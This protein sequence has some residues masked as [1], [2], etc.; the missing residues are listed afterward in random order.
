VKRPDR[1]V[2]IAGAAVLLVSMLMVLSGPAIAQQD[3]PDDPAMT[4]LFSNTAREFRAG[5]NAIY[6]PWVAHD[7]DFGLGG[8][9]TSISVQNLEDRDGQIY[10]YRGNGNGTWSQVTTA[11]LSAYASKTF[12]ASDLG[13]SAGDGAPMAVL[14]WHITPAAS[15]TALIETV[16]TLSKPAGVAGAS[17]QVLA[18]VVNEHLSESY[19]DPAPFMAA[20][21]FEYDEVVYEQ[22]SMVPWS[23]QEQLQA[24]LDTVNEDNTGAL[25]NPFGGLNADGDCL[26]RVGTSSTGG[27][28]F[29]SIVLGGIA[30]MAVAG[31]A[32]PF[33]SGADRAVSGY[34][35]INGLEVDQFNNWYLPIVQTNCGPG[36][37]WD[38]MIRVANLSDQNSA[39]T[40]RFFA[41]DD[42]S[43]SFDTGFQV[44][45]LLS[46][47]D[48]WHIDLGS[49]V[50]EG[51]V[52]SAHIL[53]D[54]WV[55]PMVDRYKVGYSMWLTNTG[56]AANFESIAQVENANGR[57]ALFAPH[58]LMG[59]FGWNTGINVANLHEG[60]N[61]IS[62]QY[63]NMVG[64]A[65]QVL[66]QR[67]AAH[68]MTYFYDPSQDGPS[69]GDPNRG[70][71]GSAI[72]W[73]DQ[74]VAV[75][76][77]ATKYP[78]A[79][80][81][82]GA[83][84]FQGT[85]YNATQNVYTFQAIP[86]VQKGNPAD[87]MGATSG[88][89]IMNPN[90]TAATANVY[91]VD[92]SGMNASNFGISGVTIPGFAN[93]FVYGLWQHNLPNGFFGAAQVISNVPVAAV[94]ANV[95]YQVEGDGSAIFNSFNPCGY[96]R[97]VAPPGDGNRGCYLGDPFDVSG[98]SVIKTFIDEDGAP[99]AGVQFHITGNNPA[100]PYQRHGVSGVD[101]T[102]HFA[103]VPVGEYELNVD[104]VPTGYMK[105]SNPADT[106]TLVQG[107]DWIE[108]NILYWGSGFHKTVCVAGTLDPEDLEAR[109]CTDI[110]LA[111]VD[112]R[113][114]E[115]VGTTAF[116]LPVINQIVFDQPTGSDGT[117]SGVLGAGNYMLCM[118]NADGVIT[119]TNGEQVETYLQQELTFDP[120]VG[121]LCGT[122]GPFELFSIEPGGFVELFNPVFLKAEGIL[123][124][125]VRTSSTPLAGVEICI[126]QEFRI[127]TIYD[128]AEPRCLTTGI[129]G[130]VTFADVHNDNVLFYDYDINPHWFE[131]DTSLMQTV[132]FTGRVWIEVNSPT[133]SIYCA[134]GGELTMYPNIE[135]LPCGDSPLNEQEQ[136]FYGRYVPT[137]DVAQD[138]YAQDVDQDGNLVGTFDLQIEMTSNP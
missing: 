85:T 42:G 132:V 98:G 104:V 79:S 53:S 69:S 74:P 82:S 90:A 115:V 59:Y 50:P 71:V 61:D 94:S 5:S 73:S 121:L 125:L 38:S 8:A 116:G 12:K 4:S 49:L 87:G 15:T 70:V 135:Y 136:K 113:I 1:A 6:Y 137:W 124:I 60:D 93:G 126:I 48:T 131:S 119:T 21:A 25:I 32:L 14:G 37:C 27:Q 97:T 111:G 18:C 10:I 56:S 75:A 99:V 9:Q 96:Y 2:R 20:V 65:T 66:N 54:G 28:F 138:G 40:V 23:S 107:Q 39:I 31:S 35:S 19:G 29:D 63:F 58:V 11:Y 88:I 110:N 68:G 83:D 109:T 122:Y 105:P 77:D 64:N 108:T 130:V 26:D 45:T 72:I 92:Q 36:G 17:T 33:T 76:V 44:E 101:G 84:L 106:F 100:F 123:D 112:V 30:K 86:L 134:Y 118:Y 3:A 46:G 129:N 52:G 62:I 120:E 114:Y 22:G 117:V 103:N 128:E 81:T 55:F 43:G 91:W 13:I 7:D 51:W 89:N 47:G 127:G 67:L 41:F 57:Y 133:H 24:I 34:N 102:A 80:A 95:D 78:I 16:V